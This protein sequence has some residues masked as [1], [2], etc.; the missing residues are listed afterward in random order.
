V[1]DTLKTADRLARARLPQ[2]Q[3]RAI[4]ESLPD[5]TSAARLASK[6]FLTGLLSPM[7][8]DLAV[9]KWMTVTLIVLVIAVLL[10]LFT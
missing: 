5:A 9:L 8:A 6:E 3:A 10:R 1:I 2:A 7:R 4:A